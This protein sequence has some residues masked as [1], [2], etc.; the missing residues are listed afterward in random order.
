MKGIRVDVYRHPLAP[1]EREAMA[2]L[3][4]GRDPLADR[5]TT[6]HDHLTLVGPGIPE[7]DEPTADA[8]AVLLCSI[9]VSGQTLLY[10]GLCD[11]EGNR[12][13]GSAGPCFVWSER[14]RPRIT[15]PIPVHDKAR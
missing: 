14:L 15:Y 8:P 4:R 11:A 6:R 12:I 9:D 7:R 10:A 5:L 2:R 13:G 1:H 3:Y